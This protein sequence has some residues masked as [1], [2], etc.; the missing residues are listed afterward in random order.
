MTL[1]QQA[2]T[3]LE[4]AHEQFMLACEHWIA[5]TYSS[6]DDCEQR[7]RFFTRERAHRVAL[8]Q[9]RAMTPPGETV[10]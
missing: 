8:Q 9:F 4:E 7:V 2:D 5:A 3:I 6:S 1:A 10:H